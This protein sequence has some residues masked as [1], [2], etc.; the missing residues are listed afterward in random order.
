MIIRRL[1]V[2]ADNHITVNRIIAIGQLVAANWQ[3][4]PI[5]I[6]LM[7]VEILS[8]KHKD[9]VCRQVRKNCKECQGISRVDRTG[10]A[11]ASQL[12]SCRM[13]E[14]VSKNDLRQ[15]VAK[16]YSRIK[17]VNWYSLCL[18]L[19]I[20]TSVCKFFI[21]FSVQSKE[22]DKENLFSNQK[23]FWLV[24]I[25]LILM[26]LMCGSGWYCREKL[27]ASHS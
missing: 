13:L 15:T 22:A 18:T 6:G 10:F 17:K 12:N 24:I 3:K 25:S 2:N 16:L 19:Y 27:D 9:G 7:N 1:P 14:I 20:L 23:L 4:Q 11:I 5:K 8:A 26:T 21:L